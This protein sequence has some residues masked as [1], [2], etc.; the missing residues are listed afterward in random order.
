MIVRTHVADAIKADNPAFVVDPFPK[1]Y[2]DNLATG[3]TYVQVY[4]ETLTRAPEALGH[5]LKVVVF[6]AKQGSAQAEDDLEGALDAVL[7]TIERMDG[8]QWSE[9]SRVVLADAWNAYEVS[10]TVSSNNAYR[11]AIL[12]S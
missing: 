6:V 9:A 12:T 3:R 5:A 2:P 1:V 11:S 7:L 4:R 8:V 10:V